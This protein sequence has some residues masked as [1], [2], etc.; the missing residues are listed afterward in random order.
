MALTETTEYDKIEVV[1][2]GFAIQVRQANIIKKD[3]V[4]IARKFNRYVLYC[5]NLDSSNNLVDADISSQPAIVQSICNA[6]WTD[7]LKESYK[8]YCIAN[9]FTGQAKA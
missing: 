2:G 6:V 9:P 4:E 3:D 1:Q 8:A 5:G 7:S